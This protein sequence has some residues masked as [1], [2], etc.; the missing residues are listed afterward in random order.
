[1]RDQPPDF[2]P[3]CDICGLDHPGVCPDGIYN[4]L[5]NREGL[6]ADAGDKADPLVKEPNE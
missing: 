2:Y 6:G 4:M 1:M 5:I 3:S